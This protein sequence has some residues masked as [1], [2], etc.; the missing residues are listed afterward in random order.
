MGLTV[1]IG[2]ILL[3]AFLLVWNTQRA[4]GSIDFD[5]GGYQATTTDANF[6]AAPITKLKVLKAAPGVLGSVVVTLTSNSPLNLYDATTTGAHSNHATT[7]I[8]SFLTTTAG[9]YTFDVS[10][11]RGLVVEVPSTVGA[12]STTITWK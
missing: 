9:T 1:I 6:V 11:S 10:F 3:T 12:A 7:T 5:F 2:A 8:A 4:V